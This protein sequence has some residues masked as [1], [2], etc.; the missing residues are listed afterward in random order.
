MDLL[1]IRF[2]TGAE[3]TL[4]LLYATQDGMRQFLCFALEDERRATKVAGE[5]RIPAGLYE[6]A[7][8]TEGGQHARYKLQY[9]DI[10]RGMI[11]VESVPGFRFIHFHVGNTDKDTDGCILVGDGASQNAVARGSLRDSVQCY[12]RVYPLIAS[13]IADSGG[14]RLQIADGG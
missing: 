8:R 13:W 3:D 9:P 14:C 12:R 5:T 4:G 10:H 6:L 2:S 7:L 11:H 1:L